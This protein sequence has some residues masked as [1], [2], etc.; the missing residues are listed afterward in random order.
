MWLLPAGSLVMGWLWAGAPEPWLLLTALDPEPAPAPT[1]RQAIDDDALIREAVRN[2][3][4]KEDPARRAIRQGVLQAARRLEQ[5]PCDDQ[6]RRE[7]GAA[8]GKF[9]NAGRSDEL[10]RVNGRAIDAR[11][12]FDEEVQ[13]VVGEVMVSGAM[14]P[15]D[16]P[17]FL[18]QPTGPAAEKARDRN[19]RYACK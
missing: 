10:L 19:S 16:L 17:S 4:V 1:F 2:G 12:V 3:Q 18:R 11:L 7:M 6:R 15:G 13:D 5:S 8:I 14:R 9:F